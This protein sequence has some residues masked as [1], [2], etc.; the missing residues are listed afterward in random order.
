MN[1]IMAVCIRF[2]ARTSLSYKS[3]F[4]RDDAAEQTHISALDF[5]FGGV[6]LVVDFL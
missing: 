6:D 1:D 2:I 4:D 5:E 3:P